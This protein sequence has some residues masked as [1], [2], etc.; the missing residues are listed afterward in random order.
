M[1]TCTGHSYVV[2]GR[3]SKVHGI[4]QINISKD[5]NDVCVLWS[6]NSAC[7]SSSTLAMCQ[8]PQNY[9]HMN[10]QYIP[11]KMATGSEVGQILRVTAM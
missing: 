1:H 10:T 4:R 7:S 11:K 8:Y 5:G 2:H 3:K 9:I 6:V